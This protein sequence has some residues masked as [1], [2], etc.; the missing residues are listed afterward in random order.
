MQRFRRFSTT[1]CESMPC[2]AIVDGYR[3]L[4][5]ADPPDL[6]TYVSVFCTHRPAPAPLPWFLR[7]SP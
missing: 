1:N 2:P 7:A 4:L 5:A 3:A 6:I